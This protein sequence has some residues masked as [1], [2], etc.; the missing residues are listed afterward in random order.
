[1]SKGFTEDFEQ[2]KIINTIIY[3]FTLQKSLHMF[4]LRLFLPTCLAGT[5]PIIS[6]SFIFV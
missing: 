4:G 6:G 2:V 5:N 3:F 1:M